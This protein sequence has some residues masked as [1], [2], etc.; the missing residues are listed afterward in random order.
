ME[1]RKYFYK[2]NYMFL[3]KRRYKYQDF[4]NNS[5]QTKPP[6]KQPEP[7]PKIQKIINKINPPENKID[8]STIKPIFIKPKT[9][10][11]WREF[12]KRNEEGMKKA[13]ESKIGNYL[14][15]ET[16]TQYIA[17]T[18]DSQDVFDWWRIPA[19]MFNNSKIYKNAEIFYNENKNDI[20]NVIGHSAGGSAT[21]ELKK[22]YPEI[23]PIT[24]NAPVFARANPDSYINTDNLPMRFTTGLDPVSMFDYD[25][26]TTYKA[27]EF[28]LNILKNVSKTYSNPSLENI[29]NTAKDIS[30]PVLEQHKM[31]GTYSNPSTTMDFLKSGLKAVAVANAAG[32]IASTIL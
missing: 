18:R 15:K 32:P 5:I 25:S 17:G 31:Q 30:S 3:K 24:Y 20:D 28:N 19:G 1:Y 12:H 29:L 7:L 26:R 4:L 16:R 8:K 13:Y 27:P 21:L 9:D 14:D 22:H 10:E 23:N 2:L 11:E 6:I